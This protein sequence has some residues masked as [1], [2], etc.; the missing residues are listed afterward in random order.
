VFIVR[1][2]RLPT[3]REA[4]LAWLL[5]I[6]LVVAVGL[7][8]GAVAVALATAEGLA[9]D[10]AFAMISDPRTSP[11]ITN[12]VWISVSIAL[13]EV[14]IVILM[15]LWRRRLH[16]PLK[17]V[18]PSG[19]FS[20]RA[21]VGAVLLPFGFAPLAE[22]AAELAYRALPQGITSE[23]VVVA[24]ARG[25]TA[26]ELV[27]VLFA[28]AVLPAI[29]EEAMFRGFVHTAFQRYSPLVALTVSSV[30]FGLFHLDP[31]Q[32]A[33]T[34]LLGVAF[35]LVRLYTGSIWPCM[36]S[37]FAYNAGVILEARWFNPTDDHVIHWGRVG[38]GLLL[39]VA[40]YALLVG[41][42]WRRHLAR[43]SFRPPPAGDRR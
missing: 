1:E 43:L 31:T 32:A 20:F 40:A 7:G 4:V 19:P 27:G 2:P 23:Q 39:M 6:A 21:A 10:S 18:L 41:D 28:A 33:G 5:G 24:V 37:H 12:P 38:V 11:L 25:T 34:V 29:A 14:T 9:P 16:M 3:P 13:N 15:L 35:G 8:V 17:L 36:L 26:T 42:L 22:V 30:L